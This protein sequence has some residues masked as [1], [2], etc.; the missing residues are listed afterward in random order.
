MTAVSHWVPTMESC[1]YSERLSAYV[2]AEA[3]AAEGRAIE[4]HV[5][6]CPACAGELA[7]LRALRRLFAAAG[8][9]PVEWP[10]H[11]SRRVHDRVDE[12]MEQ[13]GLL[14]IA[15]ALT[16]VAASVLVAA[17]ALW[18]GAAPTPASPVATVPFERAAWE[19][20]AV[21]QAVDLGP[22]GGDDVAT[23]EWILA[24]LSAGGSGGK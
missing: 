20:V 24:D 5:A 9:V 8:R 4:A 13:Q 1:E 12:L 21:A 7:E 14:R 2:D 15:R 3:G 10:G 23:P 19:R 16:A 18:M 22:G 17:A 11:V 6:T